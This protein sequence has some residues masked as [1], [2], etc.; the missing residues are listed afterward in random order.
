MR[1]DTDR[2]H[3]RSI[4]LQR[5]NYANPGAYFVTICTQGQKCLFGEVTNG[6]VRLNES[7]TVVTNCWQWLPSQYRH[8]DLDEWVVMPNHFHGIIILSDDGDVCRGGSRTAPTEAVRRKPLGGLIGAF[9]TVSTK[10]INELRGS[11]GSPLWQRNYYEH[12]IRNENELNKI[13]EYILSNPLQWALDR[14]NPAM[15]A[16]GGRGGSRTAPTDEIDRI[17]G[18]VRP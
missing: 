13:R 7:G 17:L 18:G 5:Y 4:R 10:E 1:D 8:V 15:R 6:E 2:S 12:V 16:G 3:R 14:E 11:R 9:K